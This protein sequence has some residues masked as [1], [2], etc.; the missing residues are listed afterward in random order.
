MTMQDRPW[1]A[2]GRPEG[3]KRRG[4]GAEYLK[5]GLVSLGVNVLTILG[6][7]FIGPWLPAVVNVLLALGILGV[8]GLDD[9]W[10]FPLGYWT[11]ELL[12]ASLWMSSTA[13]LGLLGSG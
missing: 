13:L 2:D 11:V 4:G 12:A 5:G 10:A 8:Y 7:L 9:R 3:G 6:W 1:P